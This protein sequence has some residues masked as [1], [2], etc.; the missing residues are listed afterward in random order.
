M[1]DSTMHYEGQLMKDLL[2]RPGRPVC[3]DAV[4]YLDLWG[5]D[6]LNVY[7]T[8]MHLH[9]LYAIAY[10]LKARRIGEIGVGRSSFVLAAVARNLGAEFITCDRFDYRHMF[11]HGDQRCEYVLGDADDFWQHPTVQKGLDFC[12]LDFLSSRKHSVADCYKAMKRGVRYLPTNGILAVHDA[13]EERYNVGRGLELLRKTLGK[14][15][16]SII[17]PYN[18]GLALIRRVGPSPYGRIEDNWHKTPEQREG[19]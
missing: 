4:T 19:A 6:A 9:V 3:L 8:S 18:Y 11:N 1:P 13:L 14:E 12:F 16:E 5:S 2:R 7:S 10:G 17:L 15:I